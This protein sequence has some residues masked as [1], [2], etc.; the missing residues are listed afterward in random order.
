MRGFQERDGLAGRSFARPAEAER[1]S[2]ERNEAERNGLL[3]DGVEW[4]GAEWSGGERNGTGSDGM[5]SD[6]E[7][8]EATALTE[9]LAER[10]DVIVCQ[11]AL[12][13]EATVRG[14]TGLA[15]NKDLGGVMRLDAA[16]ASALF[17]LVAR[18]S[19]PEVVRY[20]DLLRRNQVK[21]GRS[22]SNGAGH[23]QRERARKG[24]L[25]DGR[26]S[27]LADAVGA[28]VKEAL[29]SRPMLDESELQEVRE[30]QRVQRQRWE[31]GMES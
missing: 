24:D 10:A 2:A 20:F 29:A 7:I 9:R 11:M 30:R 13:N 18:R 8:E 1:D 25:K 14:L 12:A 15:T 3:R 23:K 19:S 17:A 31:R 6:G 26:L 27:D 16:R 22:E 21:S 28:I 5:E 4:D